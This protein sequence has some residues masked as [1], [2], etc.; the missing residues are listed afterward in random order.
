MKSNMPPGR[1]T[2]PEG[3]RK[4][5]PPP[6]SISSPAETRTDLLKWTGRG[7]TVARHVLVELPNSET[8]RPSVLGPMVSDRKHRSLQLLL[9]VL[10][11]QPLLQAREDKGELPLTAAVYARA[12]TTEKGRQWTPSYV[13][14]ALRDLEQ[15]GLI[16]RRRLPHG[17]VILPRREDG[18]A[19]YTKPGRVKDD[20]WETYFVLPPEFWIDEWFER[21]SL[22]GLAM[23][24]VIAS[25]TSN[26]P[27]VWLTN[28]K[29]AEW[30]GMS[31]RTIQAGITD[32]KKNE[33]VEVDIQWVKASGSTIGATDHHHY[34][35]TG[36]FSYEERT[37]LRR[38][39]QAELR[40]RT[41]EVDP[42]PADPK[43]TKK[44]KKRLRRK[45]SAEGESAPAPQANSDTP[46]DD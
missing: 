38:K 26:K 22:P 16:E 5:G 3:A 1:T 9:L 17:L 2:D 28:K 40:K 20:R 29:A 30:Y 6:E 39:A 31:E 37:K 4:S 27:T 14:A 32:L 23:L 36:A 7:Y 10:T 42:A 46:S 34:S 43:K 19:D 25:E 33:L 45:S 11:L 18:Q 13:S 15:R 24:L 12:L 35:L 41:L 8:N 21:L 44:T